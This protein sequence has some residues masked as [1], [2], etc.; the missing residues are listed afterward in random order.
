MNP[1]FTLDYSENDKEVCFILEK[2]ILPDENE[3]IVFIWS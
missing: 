2:H 1:I 3:N